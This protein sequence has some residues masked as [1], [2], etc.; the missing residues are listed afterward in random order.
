[1]TPPPRDGSRDRRIEDPSNLYL[2]HP[3]SHAL[4]PLALRHGVSA[5]TV[6]LIGLGCG[7]VAAIAYAHW[8]NPAMAVVG[9][10]FSVAWLIADGLD[11][12]IARA[13]KTASALGRTLDGLCDHGVFA[14]IYIALAWT[15]GTTGGWVLAIAAAGCHAVQSSLYEGERARFHRRMRGQPLTAVPVPTGMFLV[16]L[17]DSVAGSVDRIS[18]PFERRFGAAEDQ[19]AFAA[20]YAAAAVPVMRL[21]SLLTANVRVW[22]VC[23]ACLLGSPRIFFWFEIVPLTLICAVGLY[24]HRRVERRFVHGATPQSILY[25]SEQGHS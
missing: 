1:M 22:A 11:G 20:A 7:T 21:Q 16:R 9:L 15:I 24:R 14:L 2:I 3:A 18:M 19:G 23:L 4:L 6:S 8:T 12:M 5:N 17:Y 25:P 10:I 13:T